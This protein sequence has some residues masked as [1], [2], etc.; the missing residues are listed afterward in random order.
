[1][2]PW[3]VQSPLDREGTAATAIMP[4]RSQQKPAA[5]AGVATPPRVNAA[6]QSQLWIAASVGDD[7][8]EAF[9]DELAFFDAPGA[10]KKYHIEESR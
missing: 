7:L 9:L 2:W 8:D 5:T 6:G 4:P 1:M 10:A 3:F